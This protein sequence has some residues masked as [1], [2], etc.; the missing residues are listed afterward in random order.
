MIDRYCEPTRARMHEMGRDFLA[1]A[2]PAVGVLRPGGQQMIPCP[3]HAAG[4]TPRAAEPSLRSARLARALNA[5]GTAASAHQHIATRICRGRDDH[6]QETRA[7]PAACR[8]Q[9]AVTTARVQANSLLLDRDVLMRRTASKQ[10]VFWYAYRAD[11]VRRATLPARR[12]ATVQH[13]RLAWNAGQLRS[14]HAGL[15]F[16]FS[17][18]SAP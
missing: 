17:N 7:R 16:D 12:G 13:L 8:R 14:V 4:F 15:R 5:P 1:R 3:G 11:A 2:I 9:L 6:T 18:D 10:Q